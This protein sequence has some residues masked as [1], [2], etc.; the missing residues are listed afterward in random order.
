MAQ[1]HGLVSLAERTQL[2]EI[3]TRPD[4]AQA[5][6]VEIQMK[7]SKQTLHGSVPIPRLQLTCLGMT[8]YGIMYILQL[9]ADF[10]SFIF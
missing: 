3:L 2:A 1:C 9:H 7:C 10:A 6:P 4:L 8:A 5:Q